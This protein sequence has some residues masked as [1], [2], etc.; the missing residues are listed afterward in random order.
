VSNVIRCSRSAQCL[1]LRNDRARSP[2]ESTATPGTRG[3]L[4]EFDPIASA[5]GGGAAAIKEA[6]GYNVDPAYS[7]GG[8]HILKRT[9]YENI[10]AIF[11]QFSTMSPGF[12]S[13]L[14]CTPL[15][16][17]TRAWARRCCSAAFLRLPL[18]FNLLSG[19]LRKG[20]GQR[21]RSKR[22]RAECRNREPT[23]SKHNSCRDFPLI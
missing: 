1:D 13:A 22:E 21:D 20:I 11:R 19:R 2:K 5:P 8:A 16:C 17:S 7:T 12:G 10:I 15:R 14:L 6:A 18:L 3:F 9:Q 23:T 4:L